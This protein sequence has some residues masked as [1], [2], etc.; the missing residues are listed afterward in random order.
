MSEED[1]E[2][3][4]G[5]PNS[6]IST[7]V[8]VCLLYIS[9]SAA[10]AVVIIVAGAKAAYLKSLEK[11]MI[12]NDIKNNNNSVKEAN[13]AETRNMQRK[14]ELV[15]SFLRFLPGKIWE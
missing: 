11:I 2:Y 13:N 8:T 12:E 6:N 10:M 4:N 1:E 14:Q 9:I 15:K 3:E 5:N 7:V